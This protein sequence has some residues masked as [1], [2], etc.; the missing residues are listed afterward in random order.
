VIISPQ[1]IVTSCK[2]VESA[3]DIVVS[4]GSALRKATLRFNDAER[5]LCQVH[6][7]DPLPSGKPA[8]VSPSAATVEAGQDVYAVGA[9]RGMEH[10]ISRAMVS[11]LREVASSKVRL[12]QVDIPLTAGS[13]GSGVFDQNGRLIGIAAGKFRQGDTAS[14]AVP[15]DWLVELPQRN[16]DLLLTPP[17]TAARSAGSQATQAASPKEDTKP[18]TTPRVGDRWKYRLIDGK[19]PVG[20]VSIEIVDSLGAVVRERITNENEKSFVAERTVDATFKPA[21]FQDA[22]MLPGGFQIQ[23]I[24]PYAVANLDFKPGQQWSG[25]PATFQFVQVG[26]KRILMQVKVV[27][28]EKIRVPAGEF[29]AT[30]I[31]ATG[32]DYFVQFTANVTCRFWYSAQIKR[33]VKSTLDIT[34]SITTNNSN[35]ETYELTAFEAAN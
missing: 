16:A 22:V 33:T 34:Y 7:D 31:E 1:E 21:K 4:Q 30:L 25:I 26:K 6:I 5:D 23:E 18:G 32:K 15:V 3:A 12:M 28:Q 9:P 14:Y 35:G 17:L 2:V 24:S 11:S 10:A 29:N 27:R 13:I 20:I 19:K 8:M